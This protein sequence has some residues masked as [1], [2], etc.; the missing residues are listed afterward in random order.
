MFYFLRIVCFAY[1]GFHFLV[2]FDCSK[3][4]GPS[5]CC[6]EEKSHVNSL[7]TEKGFEIYVAPT[8]GPLPYL[9]NHQPE[10]DDRH[11]DMCING[12]KIL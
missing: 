7:E 11:A 4:G 8:V 5:A 1:K 6:R 9:S 12:N 10:Q 3:D 2:N